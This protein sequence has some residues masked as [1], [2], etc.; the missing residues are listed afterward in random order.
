MPEHRGFSL[1]EFLVVLAV[2]AM[3]LSLLLPAMNG[4]REA[5]RRSQCAN[6]LK[7]IGLALNNYHE[8]TN[9]F[10]P[11]WV[12]L[13]SP[14]TG[15]DAGPGWGWLPMMLP[16][17]EQRSTYDMINFSLPIEVPANWTPRTT[18]QL[19]ALVC[20][21][22]PV[23]QRTF[24]A[25]A[26][27]GNGMIAGEPIAEVGASNYVGCF[28]SGD[29]S[30]LYPDDPSAPPPGRDAGNGM[31]FRNRSVR[32]IDVDDGTSQTIAIGERNASISPATW[33]GAV[34]GSAGGPALV[35]GRAGD[36]EGPNAVPPR[37][38]DFGSG[39]PG[40]EQFLYVDGSVHFLPSRLPAPIYRALATR[41]GGESLSEDAY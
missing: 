1:I 34:T 25:V 7:Q 11:G 41:A 20:P 36:R 10:P 6:N 30:S 22:D 18:Q 31:F 8:A 40:G 32:I 33:T 21:S 3:L 13:R 14:G 29:P 24:F 9:A 39:H 4:A 16:M 17:M 19:N 28:G 38:A 12:S 27:G 37:P 26:A 23:R 2:I 5:A 15:A 35:V